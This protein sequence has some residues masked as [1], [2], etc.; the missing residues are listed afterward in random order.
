MTEKMSDRVVLKDGIIFQVAG[1]DGITV[2]PLQE[3]LVKLMEI[4]NELQSQNL[5]VYLLYDGSKARS[6]DSGIRKQAIHN[7]RK[8]NYVKAAVFGIGSV[9]LKYVANFIIAGIG[10]KG[11]IRIFDTKE[12]AEKWLRV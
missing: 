2:K 8:L 10:K 12:E 1:D 5:P 3:D 11:K 9:Y 6:P 7:M 4:Q